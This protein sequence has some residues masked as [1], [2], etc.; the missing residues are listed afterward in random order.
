MLNRNI[1]NKNYYELLEIEPTATAS[2]IT[3]AYKKALLK[4]HPDKIA[5]SKL[6]PE[7]SE[8]LTKE[9]IKAYE[10][11]KDDNKRKQYDYELKLK[12]P[13]P[14]VNSFPSP[15][16]NMEEELFKTREEEVKA[17]LRKK[18]TATFFPFFFT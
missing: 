1:E 4:Y 16:F 18:A 12:N 6:S 3:K 11:L 15:Y 5:F 8:A 10:T 14:T 17:H 7:E 13:K 2:E 9:I